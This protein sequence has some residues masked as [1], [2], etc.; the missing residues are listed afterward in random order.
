MT[1]QVDAINATVN[2]DLIIL[3]SLSSPAAPGSNNDTMVTTPIYQNLGEYPRRPPPPVPGVSSEDQPP[4][5]PPRSYQ[6]RFTSSKSE[7][8]LFAQIDPKQADEIRDA[9]QKEF[10]VHKKW[11]NSPREDAYVSELRKQARR[12]SEQQHKPMSMQVLATKSPIQVSMSQ[13]FK[14]EPVQPSEAKPLQ[15][16]TSPSTKTDSDSVTELHSPPKK[17]DTATPELPPM[18]TPLKNGE[19]EIKVDLNV[20]ADFPPPP[21]EFAEETDTH[22]SDG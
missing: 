6:S 5:L 11:E 8:F 20:T 7:S 2:K 15:K 19:V 3:F 17:R 4:A 12:Y 22:I 13:S 1:P 10:V 18:P 14:Q 16:F 21:A 9:A